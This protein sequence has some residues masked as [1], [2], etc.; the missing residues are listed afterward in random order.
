MEILLS[1]RDPRGH[2]CLLFPEKSMGF[3]I[4]EK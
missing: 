2:L 4:L 1:V 3:Q